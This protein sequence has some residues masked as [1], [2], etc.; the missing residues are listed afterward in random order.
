MGVKGAALATLGSESFLFCV[1]LFMVKKKVCTK[2]VLKNMLKVFAATLCMALLVRY[3]SSL[4]TSVEMQL[5]VGI[6]TGGITYAA[7]SILLKHETALVVVNLIQ[8]KMRKEDVH[9]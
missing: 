3:V 9:S 2:N 5:L 8:K 7:V 1:L 6:L 4:V